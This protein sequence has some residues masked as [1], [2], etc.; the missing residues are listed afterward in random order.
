MRKL[1]RAGFL[2]LRKDKVFLIAMA[3]MF[4]YGVI[5]PV[6]HYLDNTKNS[7][8]GWT[9]DT[10]LFSYVIVMPILLAIVSAFYIGSEY[11]DGTMRNKIIAG[12]HRSHIYLANLLVSSVTAVLLGI[13]FFVP[14]ICVGMPLLGAF[15]TEA[16]V[17][18]SHLLLNVVLGAAFSSIF[19]LLAMLCQNKAYTVAGCILLSFLLLFF[20]IHIF[21][22]LNEPEYYAAYSYTENGVTV[23]ED[24]C[25]NPNYLSG[26]KRKVYEFLRDF[27]PGGQVIQIGNMEVEKPVRLALYDCI[28]LAATTGCDAVIFKHKDLK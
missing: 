23:K 8:A 4:L 1:L 6:M 2:R 5:I 14:Y 21:S 16:A 7:V 3:L 18:L 27:I 17:I 12:H 15:Q 19:T 20:G 11:S 10:T 24:E 28:I 25:K 26:T 13:A 9:L 22:A